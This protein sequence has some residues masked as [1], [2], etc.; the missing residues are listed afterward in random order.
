MSD[1]AVIIVALWLFGTFWFGV[2][3]GRMFRYGRTGTTRYTEE[4]CDEC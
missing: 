3:I 2:L 4:R 1:K